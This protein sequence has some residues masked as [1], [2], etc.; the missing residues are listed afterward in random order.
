MIRST[1]VRYFYAKHTLPT[2]VEH[3]IE[4]DVGGL[5]YAEDAFFKA[6]RRKRKDENLHSFSE[7]PR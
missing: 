3:Y 7:Y 5:S 1:Q 4:R 6:K 2:D